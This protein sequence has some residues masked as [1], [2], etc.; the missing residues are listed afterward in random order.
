LQEWLAAESARRHTLDGSHVSF[1]NQLG[2]TELTLTLGTLLG[3]DMT[4]EGLLVLEASGGFLEPLGGSAF[5]FHFGHFLK[6]RI[7]FLM[8]SD[9]LLLAGSHD[10]GHLAAF[11]FRPL[12]YLGNFF[13]I[14]FNPV[15][16]LHTN[17]L[18]CHLT[19]TE[20]NRQFAAIPVLKETYQ[21]A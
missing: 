17:F 5:G 6:L 9:L 13:D 1:G 16:E 14:H 11:H 20:A 3:Q 8:K 19:S 4:G 15:H 12:F 18:V 21:V 7:L 2:T 10:H